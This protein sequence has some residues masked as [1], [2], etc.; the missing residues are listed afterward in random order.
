MP[1]KRAAPRLW[2]D[3]KRGQWAILDGGRF[4]RTGCSETERRGA[5]KQL[6]EYLGKKHQPERGPDPLIADVLLVYAREHVPHIA[7]AK[8]TTY[9]I[10]SLVGWWGS[11]STSNVTAASCR[12]YAASRSA[13]GAR[14]DLEVLRAAIGY[15]HSQYGPLVSVPRIVLPPK[16]EPRERWL[17]RSEA[18]RLLWAARRTEHLRRFILLA[19]YTGSRSKN[20]LGLRWEQVDLVA[21]VMSRRADGERDQATK[22]APPVR[23]GRRILS[24]LR[25]W[26]AQDDDYVCAYDGEPVMKLRRSFPQAVRRAGLKEVTPH[27][28]RHTAATWLMQAG[29]EPWEAA[30]FLGMSVDILQRTYAKHHPDYQRNAAEAL[31]GKRNV[32]KSLPERRERV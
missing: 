20:V 31:S 1:R 24:H 29:V 15:W 11:Q 28:L 22:R 14:R 3:K 27:T 21:G 8:N 6:A 23:L 32:A 16:S 25:R 10:S 26:R 30:G 19:L 17:T 13:G 7:G 4:I 18:A 9:N 2:L 12:A 5:E